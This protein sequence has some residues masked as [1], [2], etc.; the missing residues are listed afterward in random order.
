MFP[1]LKHMSRKLSA[2]F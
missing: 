2:L 1:R